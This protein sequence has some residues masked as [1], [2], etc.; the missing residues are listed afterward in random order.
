MFFHLKAEMT[1][2]RAEDTSRRADALGIAL[3]HAA[4]DSRFRAAMGSPEV[5]ETP[6]KW[7]KLALGRA[8]SDVHSG[9]PRS[10]VVRRIRE[11]LDAEPEL[12]TAA[13]E[14]HPKLAEIVRARTVGDRCGDHISQVQLELLTDAFALPAKP[15]PGDADAS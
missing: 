7:F 4:T 11:M 6:F 5:P 14:H 15:K 2:N 12:L 1:G 10:Q 8:Y 3:M 9:L 13:R